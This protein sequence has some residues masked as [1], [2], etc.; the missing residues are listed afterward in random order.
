[1]Q[2]RREFLGSAS[3]GVLA[4]AS[5]C[6]TN[7]SKGYVNGDDFSEFTNYLG[8]EWDSLPQDK[9]KETRD[10][11]NKVTEEDKEGILKIYKH[12][13]KH[14]RALD[15]DVRENINAVLKYQ[16]SGKFEEQVMNENDYQNLVDF[17]AKVPGIN[18]KEFTKKD[19]VFLG[20]IAEAIAYSIMAQ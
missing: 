7:T 18:A 16:E 1:M 11:W 6:V 19:L 12:P 9:Q 15:K 4:L 2:T 13:E 14:Y 8:N 5:G 10:Y 20:V 3:L 17:S